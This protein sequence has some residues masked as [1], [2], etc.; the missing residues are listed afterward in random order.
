MCACVCVCLCE[1]DREPH[2]CLA[3]VCY[4][5]SECNNLPDW[6]TTHF[7]THLHPH[8]DFT[9]TGLYSTSYTGH[10]AHL[11]VGINVRKYLIYCFAFYEMFFC[12]YIS[13]SW[14]LNKEIIS[15]LDNALRQIW[16]LSLF[17]GFA[18]TLEIKFCQ[19]PHSKKHLKKKKKYKCLNL[20]V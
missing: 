6:F 17:A 1:T 18:D 20:L 5:S 13:G 7:V 11:Q 19:R 15:C 14:Y 3:C 2:H 16:I 10:S 4:D 8:A 9:Y 12:H